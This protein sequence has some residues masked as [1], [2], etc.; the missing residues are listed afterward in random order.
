MRFAGAR[1]R[2]G[3]VLAALVLVLAASV[4]W[5][6]RSAIERARAR[7]GSG[8]EVVQTKCG[9]IEYASAGSGPPV[10]VVHGAGGGF[11]QGLLAAGALVDSGFRVIAPS[12]FGYLRTPM[13]ANREHLAERQA[14]AHV[15]LLDALGISKVVAFGG[16][17]GAPSSMRLCLKYPERCSGLVLLVPATYSPTAASGG[18]EVSASTRFVIDT[19]LRSD[20][21]FWSIISLAPDVMIKTILATPPDDVERASAAEKARIHEVLWG[22]LP[23]SARAEGLQNEALSI[24]DAPG[25][26]ELRLIKTATLLVSVENDLFGTYASAQYAA[27]QIP[28]ARFIG[29]RSGGHTWVGHHADVWNE[30]RTFAKQRS[31]PE[32]AR[33]R[34]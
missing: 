25:P 27:S 3:A 16:S 6:Y 30:I 11:D 21:I 20:F 14:D 18:V 12:R 23:V 4:Y 24:A 13:P 1:R 10:L 33:A 28:N 15:C 2:V 17:A 32:R 26:D 31:V 29:Y 5:Q 8:S 7:V 22:I 9:A 34:D 19:T